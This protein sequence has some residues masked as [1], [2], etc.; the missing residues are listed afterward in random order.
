MTP[1]H[2][3]AVPASESTRSLAALT[4]DECRAIV[5]RHGVGRVVFVDARGPVALP[6]NYVLD[7]DD[8]VF[9]TDAWSSILAATTAGTVS[10]EVD[11]IDH[12][13]RLGWSVLATGHVR[14]VDDPAD[15]R[16]VTMLRV[17]S[18][19]KGARDHYLRLTVESI[20]GRRL[21]LDDEPTP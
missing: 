9:R 6:V 15:L 17:T 14:R 4:V 1:S 10:F 13:R 11:E 18:W 2:D 8:F 20:T 7:H 3:P 16:H 19:A 5:P 21:V 12:E